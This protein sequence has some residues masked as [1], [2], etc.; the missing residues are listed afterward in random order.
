MLMKDIFDTKKWK[1]ILCTYIR[2]FNMLSISI[3]RSNSIP[4]R[5]NL[6]FTRTGTNNSKIYME[7]KDSKSQ[8]NLE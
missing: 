4:T 6:F 2:R 8:S 5:R 7:L 3:Y 1:D